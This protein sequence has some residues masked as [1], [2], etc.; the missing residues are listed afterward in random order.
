MM[1]VN[2]FVRN[3]CKENCGIFSQIQTEILILKLLTLMEIPL[4][5]SKL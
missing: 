5:M 3:N 1:D 4:N 2:F